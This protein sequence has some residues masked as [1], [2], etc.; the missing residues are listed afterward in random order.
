M[1]NKLETMSARELRELLFW[2]PDGMTVEELRAT[3]FA[4]DDLDKQV[5]VGWGLWPVLTATAEEQ[6]L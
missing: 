3:L 2:L 5:P 4:A 1:T 6:P